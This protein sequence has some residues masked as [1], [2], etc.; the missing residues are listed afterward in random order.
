MRGYL[1]LLVFAYHSRRHMSNN[2]GFSAGRVRSPR[3]T[4]SCG[5][6]AERA[7]AGS[8]SSRISRHRR[9]R[10]S[11]PHSTPR[12]PIG[13]AARW[14]GSDWPTGSGPASAKPQRSTFWG[15][16]RCRPWFGPLARTGCW[17]RSAPARRRWCR[18]VRSPA[19]P[20][21][22]RRRRCPAL[23]G[24]WRLDLGLRSSCAASHGTGTPFRSCSW[25]GRPRWEPSNGSAQTFSSWRNTTTLRLAQPAPHRTPHAVFP[26]RGWRCYAGRCDGAPAGLRRLV[27]LVGIDRRPPSPRS[28]RRAERMAL[29]EVPGLGVEPLDVGL[30]LGGLDPPLPSTPDLDRGQVTVAHQGVGLSGRDVQHFGDIGEKEKPRTRLDHHSS[31]CIPAHGDTAV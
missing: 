25:T 8:G 4:T 11:R 17:S 1:Y 30:E 23:R 5:D 9:N 22:V 26:S 24:G 27:L 3:Q 29:D 10:L 13:P 28:V 18:S 16:V 7:C 19:C 21:W 14:H 31:R 6:E 2:R 20:V 12:W 15:S